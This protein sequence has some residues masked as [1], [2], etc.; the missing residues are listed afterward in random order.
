MVVSKQ[1]DKVRKQESVWIS[2]R[3]HILNDF[4]LDGKEN[5][6]RPTK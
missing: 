4:G 5:V 1:G 6:R 2:L 3:A